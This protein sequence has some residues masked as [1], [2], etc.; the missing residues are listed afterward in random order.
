MSSTACSVAISYIIS[1]YDIFAMG[2][3]KIEH[4]IFYQ[5]MI[6]HNRLQRYEKIF[7]YANKSAKIVK[8]FNFWKGNERKLRKFISIKS[9]IMDTA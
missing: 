6:T 1:I 4:S 7:N 3:G 5:H 2:G 9:R 8:Y